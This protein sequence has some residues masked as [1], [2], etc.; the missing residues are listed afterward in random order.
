MS[1]FSVI[2]EEM[3]ESDCCFSRKSLF[4]VVEDVALNKYLI[5]TTAVSGSTI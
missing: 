2:F 5:I 3:S 4:K 1:A